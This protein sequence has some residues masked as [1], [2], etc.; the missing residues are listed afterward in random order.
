[1]YQLQ[2]PR[3][4]R[5]VDAIVRALDSLI[6]CRILNRRR[7][8][9]RRKPYA[10]ALNRKRFFHAPGRRGRLRKSLH[11]NPH[12]R[13][14]ILQFRCQNPRLFSRSVEEGKSSYAG[15]SA[16]V[17]DRS[18]GTAGTDEDHVRS[19]EQ[20]TH[21]LQRPLQ[22]EV[23]GV[24]P[25]VAEDAPIFGPNRHQGIH[26]TDRL[27]HRFHLRKERDHLAL[28][29]HRH[30]ESLYTKRRGSLHGGPHLGGTLHRKGGVDQIL[31]QLRRQ[32]VMN[33]RRK[34]MGHRMPDE[35]VYRCASIDFVL[36]FTQVSPPA[37]AFAAQ[38]PPFCASTGSRTPPAASAEL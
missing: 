23:I 32:R 2:E 20:N 26:G 18:R 24:A 33:Q 27:R 4:L 3:L 37:G 36:H 35:P 28:I 9:I 34:G 16:H 19:A 8:R 1:M 13:I 21:L 12:I 15:S 31:L 6:K 11:L 29:R 5:V 7:L 14:G 25:P 17:T 38:E 10:G 30:I 22:A